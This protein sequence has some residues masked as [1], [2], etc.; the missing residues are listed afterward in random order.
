MLL[1]P[2]L[3]CLYLYCAVL[4]GKLNAVRLLLDAGADVTI[5]EENG[6]TPMHGED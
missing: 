2:H 6:Y 5:G 1:E 3:L 4:S